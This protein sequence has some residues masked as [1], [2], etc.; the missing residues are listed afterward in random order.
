MSRLGYGVA[1][2]AMAMLIVFVSKP[3]TTFD[4][5]GNVRPFGLQE[6]E[7][8]FSLGVVTVVLAVVSF[9]IFALIDLVFD[10]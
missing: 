1:F 10:A 4:E 5:D 9:Y 8:L 7:T 2:F 3:V 6:G